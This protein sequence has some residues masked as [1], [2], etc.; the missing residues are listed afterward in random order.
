MT[1]IEIARRMAALGAREEALRAYLLVLNGD[2]APEELL[3][4]AVFLL[5]NGGDAQVSYTAF[6]QLF[7]AG[8]FRETILPLLDKLF[9]EPSRDERRR[10]YERSCALLAKYPYLFRK[11]FPPFDDL[12]LRFYPYGGGYLPYDVA[13]GQ[14]LDFTDPSEPVDDRNFFRNPDRPVLADDVYSQYELDY[15]CDNVRP[16]EWIGRENHIYLHYTD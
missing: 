15:L 1:T 11:D 12:P 16:S 5:E 4:A 3:E 6:V 10:R 13:N 14:F 9:Y 8:F 2:A 7:N